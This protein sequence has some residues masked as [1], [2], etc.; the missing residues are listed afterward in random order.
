MSTIDAVKA[1]LDENLALGGRGFRFTAATQLFGTL[2]ELDSFAV[3][4]LVAAL[5]SRF[6]IQLADDDVSLESFESV[7]ALTAL[8][9]RKL[10]R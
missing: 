5:E 6:G 9:E 4:G 8:V 3:V 1:L 7:G 10:S 2:P